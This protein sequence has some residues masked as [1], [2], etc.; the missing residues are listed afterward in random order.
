MT[1][2][3]I[4]IA[5]LFYYFF[6]HD[7]FSSRN[8]KKDEQS[9]II[10]SNREIVNQKSLDLYQLRNT[11]EYNFIKDNLHK[12]PNYIKKRVGDRVAGTDHLDF[13][14]RNNG[15]TKD[16]WRYKN[17]ISRYESDLNNAF[18]NL[19]LNYPNVISEY[20]LFREY[21]NR[22]EAPKI[23]AAAKK[24]REEETAQREAELKRQKNDFTKK[25]QDNQRKSLERLL[26]NRNLK[27]IEIKSADTFGGTYIIRNNVNNNLYVGSSENLYKRISTHLTNLKTAKHHSY[28]L[29]EEFNQFGNS[30]F[31]CFLIQS[32]PFQEWSEKGFIK[33]LAIE[34]KKKKYRLHLKSEESTL[35][36]LLEPFYNIETD[37]RGSRHWKDNDK[38]SGYKDLD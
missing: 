27:L 9:S 14:L 34:D 25:I 1:I 33:S 19:L 20:K 7:L 11:V 21:I 13:L 37:T 15:I 23:E 38:Y 26:F 8:N 10:L 5:V 22:I 12:Y 3:Y 2:V 36:R 31:S 16:S 32:I 30:A 4:L 17:E 18:E 35:I 29:Q 28:K 6:L 24:R